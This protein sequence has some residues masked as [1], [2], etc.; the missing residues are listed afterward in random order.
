MNSEPHLTPLRCYF[1]AHCQLMQ[2]YWAVSRLPEQ[3]FW[4]SGLVSTYLL[5]ATVQQEEQFAMRILQYCNATSMH[6]LDGQR[7][8]INGAKVDVT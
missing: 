5:F 3:Q 4:S 1:S 6:G 2:L 7:A 8:S